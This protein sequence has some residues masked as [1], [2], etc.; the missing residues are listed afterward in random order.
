MTGSISIL[1]ILAINSTKW[2]LFLLLQLNHTGGLGRSE[3][4]SV[5]Y[6]LSQQPFGN[7]YLPPQNHASTHVLTESDRHWHPPCCS[8]QKHGHHLPSFPVSWFV[9]KIL[10]VVPSLKSV[11][12]LPSLMPL[13]KTCHCHCWSRLL[14]WT[15]SW[16]P[17]LLSVPPVIYY[18]QASWG[19]VSKQKSKP[20]FQR[21]CITPG[22]D[23]I[24]SW[25]FHTPVRLSYFQS[26]KV[27]MFFLM[28]VCLYV[29][30]LF[31]LSGTSYPPSFPFTRL[32]LI[33]WVFTW[34]PLPPENF[35]LWLSASCKCTSPPII[36]LSNG[37]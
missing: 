7:N 25:A 5:N 24:L 27:T 19:D 9:I 34:M 32:L 13:H 37:L 18:L 4:I 15:P 20:T 33:L 30:M 14:P 29:I 31:L 21:L 10:W 12:L 2:L 26:F 11:H 17:V 22:K 23:P 16:F 6:W 28:H 35:W 3:V 36:A 1:S 8:S